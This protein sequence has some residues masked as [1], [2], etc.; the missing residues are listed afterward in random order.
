MIHI[1]LST[2]VNKLKIKHK[3]YSNKKKNIQA[4]KFQVYIFTKII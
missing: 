1:Y 3:E 2:L 4:K